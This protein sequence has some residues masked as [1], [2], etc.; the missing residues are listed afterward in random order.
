M[1]N[2]HCIETWMAT[3]SNIRCHHVDINALFHTIIISIL[4]YHKII[5]VMK[6]KITDILISNEYCCLNDEF[7]SFIY[8]YLLY[9]FILSLFTH[10]QSWPY[11]INVLHDKEFYLLYIHE[12]KS[13]NYLINKIFN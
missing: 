11:M 8:I 6:I 9:I 5:I 3:P 4:F 1:L 2:T 10:K 13:N 7:S 12:N